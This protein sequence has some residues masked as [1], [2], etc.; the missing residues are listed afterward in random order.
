MSVSYV[1]IVMSVVCLYVLP[2]DARIRTHTPK[3]PRSSLGYLS[4]QF[5]VEVLDSLPLLDPVPSSSLHSVQQRRTISAFTHLID[6]LLY[7]VDVPVSE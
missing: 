6:N 5:C 3:S 2:P 1:F 4:L 7:K